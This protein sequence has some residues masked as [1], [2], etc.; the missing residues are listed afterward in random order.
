LVAIGGAED[1][2]GRR[3]VLKAFVA[4][5]GGSGARIVVIPTASSMGPEIVD[6]Y[7]AVF[8]RLGAG[9]VVAV[10]PTSRAEA[11]DPLLAGVLD[12][13]AGVFMTGGN[14]L[15]LAALVTG[16]ALG[17]A[18]LAA[19][20]RGAVVGGTSAGASI[21]SVHMVAFGSGGATPKQRMTQVSAG[22]GLLT[23]CVVDQHFEQRNRYGRLL[24]IVAQSP[25]LLGIGVD[26]DTAAVVTHDPGGRRLSVAGRGAVT[27]VDGTAMVTNAFEARRSSPLLVSGAALHV[28]PAGAAFD[29]DS[30]ALVSGPTVHDPAQTEEL[31]VAGRDLRR[32]ARDIDAD[33]VSPSTLRRR[34]ARQVRRRRARPAKPPGQ[35]RPTRPDPGGEQ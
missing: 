13:A 25:S 27:V 26:E 21:L 8:R 29:L 3:T 34:Q 15:K 5:A 9:E 2:L 31:A 22:L 20:L 30:R 16:T 6:V 33:D 24:S 32:L 19:H 35:A 7:A 28:L 10:R 18:V 12:D 14:Q 17:D 1:K 11:D 23:G 4:L